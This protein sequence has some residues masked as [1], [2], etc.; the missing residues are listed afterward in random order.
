MENKQSE[1]T[2]EKKSGN[3]LMVVLLIL[4]LLGNGTFAW[5]WWKERGRANTTIIE[6]QEV[7]IERDNVKADLIALQAEYATLQTSDKALQAE[8][9][10]KR[11]EI[12]ELIVQA[13][14]HK[15]DSYIIYK[16]KKETET[17]RKIMQH[18]VVQ[19]DSLGTLNKTII[20]EKEKVSADLSAEKDKTTQLSKDKD[21]LQSTEHSGSGFYPEGRKPH[22]QRCEV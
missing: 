14:K 18:F 4:L 15:N 8:L 20:A 2:P 21:A 19:I 9:E 11:V 13:E 5:L 22:H 16:L 17:L 1:K 12:A 10:A 3:R 7:I 6:K